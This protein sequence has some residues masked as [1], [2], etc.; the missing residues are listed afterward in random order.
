M[1]DYAKA[2]YRYFFLSFSFAFL[3]LSLTFLFLMSVVNPKA[4][5]P[6]T[7]EPETGGTSV[8]VPTEDDALSVLFIGT[9]SE[10][11]PPGT[12]I[13]AR[14]DPA[15]GK[16]PIIVFPPQ[17]AVKNSGKT[18]S[19][20]EVSKYGGADYTRNTLAETL[21]I[22]IDRYVSIRLDSFISGAAAIGSVE[23]ELTEP[24]TITRSGAPV[25]FNR[26]KQLLDGQKVADVIRYGDYPGGELQRCRISG[27]LTAA[28]INQRMDV[29]RST[30][31]DNIF[32]KLINLIN[33]DISYHDYY[34]R[35]NAAEFLA[36]FCEDPAVPIAVSG[37]WSEDKKL[38]ILSDT[39]IALLSQTMR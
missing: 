12:F 29:C 6:S 33:T 14:F 15:R 3:V 32:E 39:F 26:G 19:L 22:P 4:S 7:P 21:G 18:E 5:R 16:V 2:K 20:F 36:R 1:Y 35:K 28:I 38:Y 11:S 25:T 24:V 13:L 10:E 8:Y 34:N 23:Y 31:I 37:E 27:E 30:V 9:Y 17:T